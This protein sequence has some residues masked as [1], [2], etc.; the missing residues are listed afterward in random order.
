MPTTL[1]V[2]LEYRPFFSDVDLCR[3]T[4]NLKST[5]VCE[6][7]AWPAHECVQAACLLDYSDSG[8]QH[9]VIGVGKDDLRAGGGDFRWIQRLDA[10]L[11]AHGHKRRRID[12]AARR[13]DDPAPG[14]RSGV[15]RDEFERKGPWTS[16]SQF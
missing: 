5:A 2:R 16:G 8:P 1:D 4:E 15:S 12:W 13:R 3:Q 6:N 7:G 9:Q 14:L 11:S 10:R